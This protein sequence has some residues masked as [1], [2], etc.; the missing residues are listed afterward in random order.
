MSREVGSLGATRNTGAPVPRK[1][2]R[3]LLEIV[4]LAACYLVAA[5]VGLKFAIPPGNATAIWPPSGIALA[6]VLLLG[7]WA[8]PGIWLAATLANLRPTNAATR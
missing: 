1:T 8:L 4:G 2:W 6:G 7:P 5:F 3:V